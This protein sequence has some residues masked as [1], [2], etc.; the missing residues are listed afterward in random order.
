MR[1]PVAALVSLLFISAACGGTDVAS[2]DGAAASSGA[3]GVAP[4]AAGAAPPGGAAAA[5]RPAPAAASNFVEGKDYVLLERRLLLDQD[6]FDRPVEAFSLLFP[7][8]WTVEGGV[9]WKGLG[10]C[11]ADIV[12]NEVTATSPDGA[13]RYQVIPSRSFLYAQDQMTQQIYQAGARA[14]GCQLNAPFDAVQ[15]I[16]GYA[17]R[18]L[19]ATASEVKLDESRMPVA[20]QLD[21]QA[22][23]V[24]QQY[25]NQLQQ[26][27]T[28]AFGKI[29]WPDGN[30][31]ILEVGVSNMVNRKPNM[32]TGVASTD[33]STSV[34]YCVLMRFPAARREEATKLFGTIQTSFRQ[35][36]VWKQA[37][38]SFLTRVGNMEQAG[39]LETLRL[40]GE[41][42]ASYAK[43]QSEA[44]DRQMRSWEVQ[45]DSQ[46]RQQ[47]AFVQTIREVDTWRD[48]KGPIELSSG[49]GQAWSRGDGSYLLS[50]SPTF[51]PSSVFQDQRW[52]E[53]KRDKPGGS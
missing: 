51:D 3:S 47:K 1:S 7:R 14:G 17:Q 46:D 23:Q 6:R 19:Q 50:N 26:Q 41:Q 53:M 21:A 32:V 33:S 52:T 40:Q 38:D 15:Y 35:N 12:G 24:A 25:G 48:A 11:R 16:N 18:D 36:P 37:K 10:A 27:T 44:Q 9:K 43:S 4:A 28:F 30:E 45:Q 5:P 13:I 29:T 49:Y 8:G 31:G 39:R 34:F 42:A 20:R 2:T 22:M